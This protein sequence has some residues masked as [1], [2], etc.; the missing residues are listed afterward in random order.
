MDGDGGA[1]GFAVGGEMG[2]EGEVAVWMDG[3]KNLARGGAKAGLGGVEKGGGDGS[4]SGAEIIFVV[5][6]WDELARQ[7]GRASNAYGP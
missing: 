1:A 4:R 5:P 6:I 2:G 7:D 3:G